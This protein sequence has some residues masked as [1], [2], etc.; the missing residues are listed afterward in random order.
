MGNGQHFFFILHVEDD[1][2]LILVLVG[3]KLALE[4]IGPGFKYMNN[5]KC[6]FHKIR[7]TFLEDHQN[8]VSKF[9]ISRLN[10]VIKIETT[11]TQ[12]H[13]HAYRRT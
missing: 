7:K 8:D 11:N 12:K 10:G 5:T 9:E 13:K 6:F 1:W 2:N 3:R 4:S